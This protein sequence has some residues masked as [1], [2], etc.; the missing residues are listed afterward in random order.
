M[1]LPTKGPVEPHYDPV[2]GLRPGFEPVAK[3]DQQGVQLT[4]ENKNDFMKTI[5][6]AFQHV[7]ARVAAFLAFFGILQRIQA[8]VKIFFVDL[9]AVFCVGLGANLLFTR[10]FPLAFVM[11]LVPAALAFDYRRLGHFAWGYYFL[12][13]AF[14]NLETIQF[15]DRLHLFWLARLMGE[16][17]Y[18]TAGVIVFFAGL[19]I[20]HFQCEKR[21]KA[22]YDKRV[23]KCFATLWGI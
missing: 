10:Y 14:L 16:Y 12:V 18:V 22:P 2:A 7:L 6:I 11:V 4:S 13:P 21:G 17:G 19:R 23:E 1:L 5:T 15:L 8:L 20:Y 9:C 3:N